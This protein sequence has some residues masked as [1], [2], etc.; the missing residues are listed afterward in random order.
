MEELFEALKLIP[1]MYEE[2]QRLKAQSLIKS[3]WLDSDEAAV[4]VKM[5]KETLL[6]KCGEVFFEGTHYYKKSAKGY[7]FD[8]FALDMWIQQKNAA[9]LKCDELI[10][11]IYP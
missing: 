1:L 6:K 7:Y 8:K 10:S 5:K 2:I 11:K 4:Y 3:Q 9:Q